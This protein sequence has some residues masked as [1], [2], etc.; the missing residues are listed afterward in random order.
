MPFTIS[1]RQQLGN[2]E[3][4]AATEPLKN[5]GD[6]RHRLLA[7]N[8]VIC[9][10]FLKA[11]GNRGFLKNAGEKYFGDGSGCSGRPGFLEGQGCQGGRI[12]HD[13]GT[14]MIVLEWCAASNAKS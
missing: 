7:V 2:L 1:I 3:T 11:H 8:G 9:W 12:S 10:H 6:A 5:R 14:S 4:E 13:H